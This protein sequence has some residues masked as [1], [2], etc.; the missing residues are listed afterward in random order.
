MFD[1]LTYDFMLRAF[2]AVLAMSLFAPILG[3]FLILRSQSLMSDTLSHVSLAGVAIGVA[4]GLSPTWTTLIIVS[5]AAIFLEYLRSVYQHYME[6]ATAILMSAGLALSL[7]IMSKEANA[8]SLSLDQYLFGS[9]IT[10]SHHQVLAL[11]ALAFLILLL[12]GLFIRP[13]YLLTFDED[14]ALVDGLPVRLMSI[15]FN[16]ITGIAIAL[17]I[18]AAGA[19]LVSTIMVLPASIAMRLGNSFRQVLLIALL[20]SFTGMVSGLLLS[21]HLETPASATITMV[22]VSLFLLVSGI[23]RG[24]KA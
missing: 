23:K 21:Y 13:M 7:M 11:F 17:M 9:I 4:M 2:L 14:T 15:L 6:I 20:T 3:V 10:I 12:T 16:I 8:S 1:L 5:L 19:L 22:F 18:P 24:A